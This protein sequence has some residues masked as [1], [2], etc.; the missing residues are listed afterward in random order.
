MSILQSDVLSYAHSGTD[1]FTEAETS[2]Q[3][4]AGLYNE[5]VQ[6]ISAP[7]IK[8]VSEL[9]GKTVCVGDVGSGTEVNARQVLEAYGMTTADITATNGSFGD[10][11]TT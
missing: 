3:W 6:I 11:P 9:K 10:A 5:T 7:G 1:L 8:D 4:V 2:S